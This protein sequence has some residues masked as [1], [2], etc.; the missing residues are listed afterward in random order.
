MGHGSDGRGPDVNLKQAK[1]KLKDVGNPP[2]KDKKKKETKTMKEAEGDTTMGDRMIK[3]TALR[4]ALRKGIMD[5]TG[6]NIPPDKLDEIIDNVIDI[7]AG[8]G[9]Q[10]LRTM[11]Y[12]KFSKMPPKKGGGNSG[13]QSGILHKFKSKN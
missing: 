2:K 3:I 11:G 5:D 4:D 9:E 6:L 10:R 13:G 12:Q 1:N 8:G 7:A